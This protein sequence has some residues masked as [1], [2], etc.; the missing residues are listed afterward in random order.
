MLILGADPGATT[1]LVLADLPRFPLLDGGRIK[2]RATVRRPRRSD[3]HPTE[4]TRDAVLFFAIRDQLSM[5]G[6]F[7]D[8]AVV[9]RPADQ[10]GFGKLQARGT[11]FSLGS[12]YALTLAA[13]TDYVSD[14]EK[15]FT[16]PVLDF[17]NE[18]GWMQGRGPFARRR[19]DTLAFAIGLA[20]TLGAKDWPD[21][22][23]H[24]LMAL[25]LIAFHCGRVAV[26]RNGANTPRTIGR[27][28]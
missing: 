1:G 14:A 19:E 18:P 4:A 9:E 2:G 20:R 12:V 27:T 13:A 6:G 17:H 26:L 24:E 23:E 11:A 16:Y 21:W 7:A 3:K 25:G 5:W 8:V 10:T 15:T 22:S 28:A